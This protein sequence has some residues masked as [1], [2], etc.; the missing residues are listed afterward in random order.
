MVILQVLGAPSALQVLDDVILQELPEE[1]DCLL[2]RHIRAKVTV[3]S[4]EVMQ[5]VYRFR[6]GEAV[7]V[8]LKALPVFLQGHSSAKILGDFIPL[9]ESKKGH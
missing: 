3:M 4:E 7:P 1:L 6:G 2:P 5:P 9:E 8:R